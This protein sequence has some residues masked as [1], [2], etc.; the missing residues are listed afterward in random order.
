MPVRL[1]SWPASRGTPV[2][3]AAG[4]L[5][6]DALCELPSVVPEMARAM[7]DKATAASGTRGW[8]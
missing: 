7:T 3:A 2:S 4:K 1:G 5:L 6:E 8:P